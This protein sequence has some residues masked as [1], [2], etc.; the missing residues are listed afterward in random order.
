MAQLQELSKLRNFARELRQN[1]GRVR[2]NS[3]HGIGGVRFVPGGEGGR[4]RQQALVEQSA[5]RDLS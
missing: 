2:L 4:G 5:T 1:Q 3:P